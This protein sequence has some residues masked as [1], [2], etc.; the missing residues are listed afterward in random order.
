MLAIMCALGLWFTACDDASDSKESYNVKM[1]A[2]DA[3]IDN[4]EVS[5]TFVTISEIRVD[6]QKV[7]GFNKTTLEVS[8]LTNGKTETL[9]EFELENQS[10]S[11]VTLVLDYETDAKGDAP[12]CY[13]LKSDGIK[14]KI[15]SSTNEINIEKEVDLVANTTTSLVLDFDLRKFVTE[16]SGDYELV[17]SSELDASVRAAVRAQAGQV[18]GKLSD[19]T[20]SEHKT[21]AYLYKKGSY[22]VLT[23]TKG[24]GQSNVQFANAVSSVT[25]DGSGQFQF[26]FVDEGEYELHLFEYRDE[27][28]DGK[29]E[30]YGKVQLG[31]TGGLSLNGFSVNANAETSLEASVTGVL[32]L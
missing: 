11:Q 5:G 9:K 12:G 26:A 27:D 31:L 7:E 1:E 29:F 25:V 32:K 2:T 8:A 19:T 17:S 13:I 21:I 24:S 23:E 3:P 22:N 6:G 15:T 14:D 20:S 18:K 4:A 16:S 10:F 28:K 30:L